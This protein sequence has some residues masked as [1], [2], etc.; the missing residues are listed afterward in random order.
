MA[1]NTIEIFGIEPVN[2]QKISRY[3]RKYLLI[4]ISQWKHCQPEERSRSEAPAATKYGPV[5]TFGC[6]PATRPW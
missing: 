6:G 2:V 5:A 1:L 3:G 4:F